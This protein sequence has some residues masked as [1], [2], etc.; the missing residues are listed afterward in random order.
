MDRMNRIYNPTTN[1]EYM[2]AQAQHP[3]THSQAEGKYIHYL[4]RTDMDHFP[5]RRFFRGIHNLD[6]PVIHTRRAGYEVR[7]DKLYSSPN[8]SDQ[9]HPYLRLSADK[10]TK[11]YKSTIFETG[12]TQCYP[13][14]HQDFESGQYNV[15]GVDNHR[16]LTSIMNR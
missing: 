9:C 1:L 8:A 2:K 16:P 6:A 12:C 7:R 13:S 3:W 4:P 14:Y 10:F 11:P 15:M 5:Y